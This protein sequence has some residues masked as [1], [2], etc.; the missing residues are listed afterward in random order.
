[1]AYDRDARTVLAEVAVKL[2]LQSLWSVQGHGIAIRS[3]PNF[4][5]RSDIPL[6][7]YEYNAPIYVDGNGPRRLHGVPWTR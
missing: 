4:S 2:D 7:V 5:H 3:A 6:Y 1:M